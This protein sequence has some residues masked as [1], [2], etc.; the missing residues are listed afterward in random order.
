M[1]S[2]VEFIPTEEMDGGEIRCAA[3]HPQWIE[4]KVA[5]YP[6]NILCELYFSISAKKLR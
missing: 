2:V 3:S 4:Q 6:L 5:V 1:E